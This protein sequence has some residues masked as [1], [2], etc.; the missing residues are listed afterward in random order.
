MSVA[1]WCGRHERN[2]K[3]EDKTF[4]VE[5][6]Q[7][8]SIQHSFNRRSTWQVLRPPFSQARLSVGLWGFG[9]DFMQAVV[10]DRLGQVIIEARLLRAKAVIFHCPA[11]LRDQ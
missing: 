2:A 11:S 3:Q 5:L 10:I 9:Q 1:L 4:H 7:Q 6:T 8:A